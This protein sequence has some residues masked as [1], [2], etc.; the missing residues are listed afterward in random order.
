M[1]RPAPMVSS[2]LDCANTGAVAVR[3]KIA[4]TVSA[5]LIDMMSSP[6][7]ITG[8]SA[9][10]RARQASFPDDFA[11]ASQNHLW[12]ELRCGTMFIARTTQ[13]LRGGTMYR[14]NSLMP[15]EAVRLAVLGTLAQAG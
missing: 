6:S 13:W 14:D 10:N 5:D 15:K 11:N 4:A 9:V 12:T 8:G 1:E 7:V 3:H 2:G